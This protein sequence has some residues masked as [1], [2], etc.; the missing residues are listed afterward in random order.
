MVYFHTLLSE[1]EKY[2]R[3]SR[4]ALSEPS[5]AI[6]RQLLLD[7]GETNMLKLSKKTPKSNELEKNSSENLE[8]KRTVK[9]HTNR[10]APVSSQ[11][12]ESESESESTKENKKSA[13]FPSK[14]AKQVKAA[15]VG[16]VFLSYQS[17]YRQVVERL[18]ERFEREGITTWMDKCVDL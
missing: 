7:D 11:G 5:K 14:N 6:R 16:H 17:G 4:A 15:P 13:G 10:R 9:K 2:C 3:S 1:L 18:R 12:S 8:K